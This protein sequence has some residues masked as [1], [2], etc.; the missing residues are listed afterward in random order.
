MQR[1]SRDAGHGNATPKA[2][3]AG[4]CLCAI[5]LL[6]SDAF[7]EDAAAV[8][9]GHG[10]ITAAELPGTP[11]RALDSK[12]IFRQPDGQGRETI[13]YRTVRAPGTRAP[14]HFHDDGGLTCVIEGE[15]TLYLEGAAPAKASAGQC[16]SMPSGKP[17][18][19]V[20][21]GSANA[22]LLDIFTVKAGAP[23][24]RVTEDGVEGIQQQ[25]ATP[26]R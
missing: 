18:S 23:A 3:C 2:W 16:Y 13:V 14:I 26:A 6:A 10:G 17:M 9:Q 12:E 22:V 5:A 20:N 8:H 24:W 15:M 7:A 11:T 21:S 4:L 1:E 25:F 19:G